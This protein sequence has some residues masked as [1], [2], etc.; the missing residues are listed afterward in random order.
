MDSLSAVAD[1]MVRQNTQRTFVLN[2]EGQLCGVVSRG[3][4]LRITMKKYRYHLHSGD[5]RVPVSRFLERFEKKRTDAM[6]PIL[7]SLFALRW[8][9]GQLPAVKFLGAIVSTREIGS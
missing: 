2:E 3:D 9:I 6:V 5:R 4:I 1:V 7:S 8:A